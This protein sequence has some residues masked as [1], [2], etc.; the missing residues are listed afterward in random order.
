MLRNG[1]VVSIIRK[2]MALHNTWIQIGLVLTFATQNVFSSCHRERERIVHH[3]TLFHGHPRYDDLFNDLASQRVNSDMSDE[4][5]LFSDLLR[6]HDKSARP[7]KNSSNAVEVNIGLTMSQIFDLEEKNQVLVAHTWL[8]QGWRDE[9]LMW[10]KDDYGGLQTINVPCHKIWLPDIVLYN[11][12][13]ERMDDYMPALAM[14]KNDGSVFWPIPSKIRST[15]KIDVTYFPFDEQVCKLKFG[16]WTYNGFQVDIVNR[17]DQVD[18]QNYVEN[19]EWQL[20]EIRVERNVVKYGCCPEPFPDVTFHIVIRRKTLYYMYN[21]VLP[22]LLMSGLTLLE[23]WLPP[24]SGEKI[25]L[26]ITILLAFSVFTLTISEK[27]P[28]TSEFI[29]LISIYV[30]TVMSMAALSVMA[31]VVVLNLHHRENGKVVP[32]WLKR[33]LS[34]KFSSFIC[35]SCTKTIKPKTDGQRSTKNHVILENISITSTGEAYVSHSPKSISNA[36]SAGHF[37]RSVSFKNCLNDTNHT[38][39]EK[40]ENNTSSSKQEGTRVNKKLS[41]PLR[42]LEQDKEFLKILTRIL[43]KYE[44]DERTREIKQEWQKVARLLD[45][46]LFCVFVSGTTVSAF[47]LLG[48][49]PMA[50]WK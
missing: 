39:E 38:K 35:G 50:R 24:E 10:N 48:V 40:S 14:V 6:Y 33:I 47:M 3:H 17:S 5:R 26:G 28:E 15:C 36:I 2:S 45:R 42:Q 11:N 27:L 7:I 32:R 1:T 9:L 31:T 16:S 21:V 25:T 46:I 34:S 29:P 13:A 12:A 20:N 8:D 49:L 44:K 22:C 18:L 4:Y 19:G 41:P 37:E 23:F 30:T 43:E